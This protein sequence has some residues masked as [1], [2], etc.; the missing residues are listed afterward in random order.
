MIALETETLLT[1][2]TYV[3]IY[4][5]KLANVIQRFTCFSTFVYSVPTL[6]A[7]KL[8]RKEAFTL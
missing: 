6:K 4:R 7:M 3:G 5:I 2:G 8:K 1:K